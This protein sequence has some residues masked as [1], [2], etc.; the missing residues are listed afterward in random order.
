MN[1]QEDIDMLTEKLDE[2][3]S[4][5]AKYMLDQQEINKRQDEAYA[6]N[7]EAIA[8]LTKATQGVVDAWATANNFQKFIKW[9]SGFAIIGALIAWFVKEIK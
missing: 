7:M 6:Q 8:T 2:H 1:N 4:V 5:C 3:I 9:L